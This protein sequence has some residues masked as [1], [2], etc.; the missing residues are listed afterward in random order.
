MC[1]NQQT[2]IKR[3]HVRGM[4]YDR[5]FF[6]RDFDDTLLPYMRAVREYAGS[7]CWFPRQYIMVVCQSE[8]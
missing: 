1:V 6:H 7:L 5:L 4:I 8:K 2:W 3:E